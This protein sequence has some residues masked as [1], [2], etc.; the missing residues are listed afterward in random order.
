MPSQVKNSNTIDHHSIYFHEEFLQKHD[1]SLFANNLSSVT[2]ESNEKIISSVQIQNGSVDDTHIFMVKQR[3]IK[4]ENF[5]FGNPFHDKRLNSLDLACVNHKLRASQENGIEYGAVT[6][7]RTNPKT[8]SDIPY[9]TE[10]FVKWVKDVRPE[11]TITKK[12][13]EKYDQPNIALID[14]DNLNKRLENY[15]KIPAL[16]DFVHDFLIGKV[17]S[18]AEAYKKYPEQFSGTCFDKNLGGIF[19]MPNPSYVPG[20]ADAFVDAARIGD[21]SKAPD[22]FGL[23]AYWIPPSKYEGH[24]IFN[25]IFKKI[26]VPPEADTN[27]IFNGENRETIGDY[28]KR[29]GLPFI[30]IVSNLRKEYKPLL[31]EFECLVENHL[32]DVYKVDYRKNKIEVYMHHPIYGDDTAGLHFHIRVNQARHAGEE[33]IQK[34][35]LNKVISI[36][37]KDEVSQEEIKE[38]LINETPHTASDKFFSLSPVWFKEQFEENGI[39]FKEVEN[40]WNRPVWS[41]NN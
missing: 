5:P 39:K 11:Y 33:D 34:L 36:L 31:D 17:N 13:A 2:N 14:R 41:R 16:P 32:I 26:A 9:A 12:A 10:S 7:A 40:P 23:V 35:T 8:A 6:N 21:R 18:K 19:I 1:T 25:N 38:L 20:K 24:P 28:K 4:L 37:A 30:S 27:K 3:R 29:T 15:D 22:G